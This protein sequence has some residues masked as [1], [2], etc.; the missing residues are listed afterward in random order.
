MFYNFDLIKNNFYSITF[1]QPNILNKFLW[2]KLIDPIEN[3]DN[4]LN[5]DSDNIFFEIKKKDHQILLDYLDIKSNSI[6][7]KITINKRTYNGSKKNLK[8]IWENF[9]N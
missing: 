4:K 9:K 3:N 1:F 5:F 6:K 8:A 2:N 7:V